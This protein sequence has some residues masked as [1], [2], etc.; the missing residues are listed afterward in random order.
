[1]YGPSLDKNVTFGE[2]DLHIIVQ[3]ADDLA[4]QNDCVVKGNSSMKGLCR[5]QSLADLFACK[6]LSHTP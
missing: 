6:P 1:M 3:L 5:D 2:V 4:L